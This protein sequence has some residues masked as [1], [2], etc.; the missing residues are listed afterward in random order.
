MKYKRCSIILVLLTVLCGCN[1]VVTVQGQTPDPKWATDYQLPSLGNIEGRHAPEFSDAMDRLLMLASIQHFLGLET[2]L[3][4]NGVLTTVVNDTEGV[5]LVKR[6]IETGKREEKTVKDPFINKNYTYDAPIKENKAQPFPFIWREASMKLNWSLIDAGGRILKGPEE[7]IVNKK[8][9]YG[10]VNEISPDGKK[11]DDLPSKEETIEELA[12]EVAGQLMAVF[13]SLPDKRTFVLSNGET[14]LGDK[15]IIKGVK[16]AEAGQW[17]EAAS[18]WQKVLNEDPGNP[19][20]LY[21]LG[22][23]MERAGGRENMAKAREYYAEA[24]RH[25]NDPLYRQALVR[26]ILTLRKAD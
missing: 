10:G 24:F 6:E 25:G 18:V 11:M 26:A 5:D 2:G 15:L 20:A 19:A 1:P 3:V 23:S 12:D 14:L 21:N 4:I 17:D 9:K 8:Q 13:V 7:I 22:V 16:L